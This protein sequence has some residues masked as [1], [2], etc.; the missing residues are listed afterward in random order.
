[1]SGTE[2]PVAAVGD[3]LRRLREGPH[4]ELVTGLAL[5][6]GL[7]LGTV[8]WLGLVAGGALV[9]FLAPSLRRALV[10]GAYLGVAVAVA[11][12]AWLGLLG[13]LGKAVA[14]GPLFGLSL[15]LAVGCPILGAGVRGL[16]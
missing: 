5:L 3:A 12:L 16:G 14:T 7:G 13:A 8:H 1:M 4:S 9:G 11:F 6:V 15:A 2:T 10:L